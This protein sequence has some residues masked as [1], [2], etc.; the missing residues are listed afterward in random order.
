MIVLCRE[1]GDVNVTIPCGTGIV[2]HSVISSTAGRAHPKPGIPVPRATVPRRFG[3]AAQRLL[4][5]SQRS[6]WKTAAVL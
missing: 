1:E 3:L 5:V 6:G 2:R 4:K